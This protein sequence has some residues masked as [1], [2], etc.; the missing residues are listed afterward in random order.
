LLDVEGSTLPAPS[1]GSPTMTMYVS[2][3]AVRRGESDPFD[4]FELPPAASDGDGETSASLER[5]D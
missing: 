5:R 1:G 4:F 3:P 2:D